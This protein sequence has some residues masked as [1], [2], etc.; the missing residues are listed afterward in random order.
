MLPAR[1]V[2]QPWGCARAH[3]RRSLGGTE[4]NG[5]RGAPVAGTGQAQFVLAYSGAAG[6]RLS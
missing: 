5:G 3:R 1:L 6:R 2:L 4:V